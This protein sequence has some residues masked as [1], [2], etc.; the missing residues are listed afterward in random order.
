MTDI[1][2][3]GYD[4]YLRDNNFNL[5]IKHPL[6]FSSFMQ[7]D[8]KTI[9]FVLNNFNIIL[10]LGMHTK[11]GDHKNQLQCTALLS[12]LKYPLLT[13][14]FERT[15]F[16][17][18][19]TN[20]PMYCRDFPTISKTIY[21]SLLPNFIYSPYKRLMT[22]FAKREFITS[23]IEL[24][25]IYP[26]YDFISQT[27]QSASI[28]TIYVLEKSNI[29]NLLVFALKNPDKIY[30]ALDLLGLCLDGSRRLSHQVIDIFKQD[31]LD[32]ESSHAKIKKIH[33]I[34]Q[35]INNSLPTKIPELIILINKLYLVCINSTRGKAV[36]KDISSFKDEYC[37]II[38]KNKIFNHFSEELLNLLI[39]IL[40]NE[41]LLTT[42]MSN[43][44]IKLCTD[45]FNFP[46]NNI[47]HNAVVKLFNSLAITK[48]LTTEFLAKTRIYDL[49][50][51]AYEKKADERGISYWGQARELATLIS[52]REKDIDKL[53]GVHSQFW[54]TKV[55]TRIN[56]ENEILSKEYGG[57]LSLIF[58]KKSY[59]DKL[60]SYIIVTLT[61]ILIMIV[62]RKKM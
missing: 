42:A 52:Q 56:K 23:I 43:V 11:E 16:A 4:T 1:V 53:G 7:N 29:A 39:N 31:V 41:R 38:L 19:L 57:N 32:T 49:L 47:L 17:S 12:K 27:I 36:A 62:F 50:F 6:F 8:K 26:A 15:N 48:N 46:Q 54:K 30:N 34:I 45:F 21:F 40:E 25:D 33:Y 59:P 61:F 28:F 58:W 18:F 24:I 10:N 55:L 3:N 22:P 14:I 37:S 60:F 2:S 20:Y 13:V 44:T 51:E 35:F 5:V 9:E